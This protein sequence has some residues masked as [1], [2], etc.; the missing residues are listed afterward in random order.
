MLP[1]RLHLGCLQWSL[2][3]KCWASGHPHKDGHKD[4]RDEHLNHFLTMRTYENIPIGERDWTSG[5]FGKRD[6]FNAVWRSFSGRSSCLDISSCMDLHILHKSKG[7]HPL[8]A[9]LFQVE[10][11]LGFFGATLVKCQGTAE[12]TRDKMV[13]SSNFATLQPTKTGRQQCETCEQCISGFKLGFLTFS[14]Q[15]PWWKEYLNFSS[16]RQPRWL[17]RK[18]NMLCFQNWVQQRS[19]MFKCTEKSS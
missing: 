12:H 18:K 11:G 5:S 13:L 8:M 19:Q 10:K 4:T 2:L 7:F 1:K 15:S 14:P 6:Y 3:K 17:W 16:H 9:C